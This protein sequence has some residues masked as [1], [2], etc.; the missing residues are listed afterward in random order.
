MRGKKGRRHADPADPPRSRALHFHGHGTFAHDRPPVLGLV[1]RGQGGL[2]L[3][4][5]ATSGRA[6]LEPRVLEATEVAT[7]VHTDEW[8]GYAGLP[9][10]Q[11][12]HATV[13]HSQ[14]QWARDADGDGINEVHCN[15]VEGLWTGLRNF[16]RPFRGVSKWYLDQYVAMFAWIHRLKRV[17]DGF[18][19][20]LLGGNLSTFDST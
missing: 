20:G 17:S 5:L 12:G 16:L 4:V 10:Q 18:L 6:A 3:A 14:G 1:G 9:E 19:R 15:S 8:P 2:A 11:R 7:Q 13:N